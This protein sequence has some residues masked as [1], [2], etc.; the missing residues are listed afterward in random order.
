MCN[1]EHILRKYFRYLLRCLDKV[2]LVVFFLY[3]NILYVCVNI[4]TKVKTIIDSLC[5]A[6]LENL[7]FAI[8]YTH[9]D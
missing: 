8:V 7:H 9:L 2:L 6:V 3:E 5:L 4:F 1:T